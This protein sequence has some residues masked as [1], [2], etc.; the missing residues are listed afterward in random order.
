VQIE[1]PPTPT[2]TASTPKSQR[3]DTPSFVATLPTINLALGY[4]SLVDL[5][6]PLTLS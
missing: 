3:Y 1:P 2:L 6:A 4:N 5:I